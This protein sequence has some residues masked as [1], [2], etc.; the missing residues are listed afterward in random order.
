MRVPFASVFVKKIERPF[1]SACASTIASFGFDVVLEPRVGMAL[2][3]GIGMALD[4]GI[5]TE[6]DPSIDAEL[7]PGIGMV[8][9]GNRFRYHGPA[10]SS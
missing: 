4:A 5:D 3:A 7:D 6:L 10:Q 2:D 8:P 1:A 9:R